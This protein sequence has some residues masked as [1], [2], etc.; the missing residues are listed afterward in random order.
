MIYTIDSKDFLCPKCKYQI[1][2]F[3]A[4]RGGVYC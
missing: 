2:I 1:A 4:H 3:G